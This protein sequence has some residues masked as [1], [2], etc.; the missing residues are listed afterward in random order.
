[1]KKYLI[2]AIV[3]GLLIFIWQFLSFALVNIHE[4]A[5]NYTEKEGDIINF[6]SSIDLPE[7]G[8]VVPTVPPGASMD[9][10]KAKMDSC[11]GKPWAII[12]YHKAMEENMT[13]NMVRGFFTNVVMILIFCWLVGKFVSPSSGTII[14]AAL[15]TGFIVFLNAHYTNHIWYETFDIWAHLLDAVVSW[16]LAGIWLSWWLR[17]GKR[18]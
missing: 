13:M 18:A 3:G 17:R 7:G 10:A 4:P 11:A 2:G 8:Y 15:A 12:Q 1:M 9:E 5:Q 14:L 6:L 16:G